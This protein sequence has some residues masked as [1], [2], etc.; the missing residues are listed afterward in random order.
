MERSHHLK[1]FFFAFRQ[2]CF[3]LTKT[4]CFDKLYLWNKY[5]L[6][7]SFIYVSVMEMYRCAQIW[8]VKYY[9]QMNQ[10][11]KQSESGAYLSYNRLY[12]CYL[13]KV[14]AKVCLEHL[15]TQ[16][17]FN[18]IMRPQTVTWDMTYAYNCIW[19]HRMPALHSL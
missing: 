14:L 11:I 19:C 3:H 1:A 18:S 9:L 7:V 5:W 12:L 13:L 2:G 6:I 17:H 8:Y 16:P 15:S 10:E 4:Y